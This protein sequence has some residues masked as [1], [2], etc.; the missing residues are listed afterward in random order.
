MFMQLLGALLAAHM[1]ADYPLQTNWMAEHKHGEPGAALASHAAVHGVMSL[2]L[3]ATTIPS[4]QAVG[5]AC[6][7]F[8]SHALTDMANLHI[9]W[10]QTVHFAVSVGLA[11]V[12][13]L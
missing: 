4:H 2:A 10:D 3:S 12:V 11:S 6:L 5:I 13:F 8:V 9:R 1:I 7:V